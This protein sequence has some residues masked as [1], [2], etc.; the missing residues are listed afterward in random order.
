MYQLNILNFFN[1]LAVGTLVVGAGP[2]ELEEDVGGELVG[3]DGGILD[4]TDDWGELPTDVSDGLGELGETD[5]WG[6]LLIDGC[7]ELEG[8][9][10]DDN[11]DWGELPIDVSDGLGELDGD[12]LDDTDDWGEQYCQ[13]PL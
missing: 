10:L 13:L 12:M 1:R 6:E 3:P 2:A 4:D 8:D 11:D 5:D 7:E 9:M